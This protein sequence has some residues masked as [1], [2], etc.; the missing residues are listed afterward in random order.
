MPRRNISAEKAVETAHALLY[1]QSLLFNTD[2]AQNDDQISIKHVFSFH[3][4]N[5]LPIEMNAATF[6]R[7]ICDGGNRRFPARNTT[8]LVYCNNDWQI[9]SFKDNAWFLYSSPTH[10]IQLTD[11]L[12]NRKL[13]PLLDESRIL[14]V[15][16]IKRSQIIP[17]ANFITDYR[18][19]EGNQNL[20]M[21][22]ATQNA[23][24]SSLIG[25]KNPYFSI[26]PGS[27]AIEP[28]IDL[29]GWAWLLHVLAS[30]IKAI[31]IVIITNLPPLY[32]A[33]KENTST[34]VSTTYSFFMGTA[35]QPAMDV[36]E[37]EMTLTPPPELLN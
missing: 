32:R 14:Q 4:R 9:L 29:T 37:P 1:G 11:A 34:L 35:P 22:T 27:P 19:A 17:A 3:K 10:R 26:E 13:P 36:A 8:Y 20:R 30:S 7:C 16:I 15:G 5:N 6:F 12:A 24:D 31:L 21:R 28:E 33:I 18:F 25:L 2:S 23:S